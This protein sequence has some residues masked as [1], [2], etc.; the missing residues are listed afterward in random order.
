MP[1]NS[2]PDLKTLAEPEAVTT[3]GRQTEMRATQIINVV[4]G[5]NFQQAVG[6]GTAT[7]G[8]TP[9]EPA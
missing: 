4:T 3:S 5:F 2:A 1:W 7:G 6:F 9:N 8:A